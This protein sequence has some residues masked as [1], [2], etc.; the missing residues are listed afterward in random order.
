MQLENETR[1]WIL[2]CVDK[3]DLDKWF[4]AISLQIQQV[5]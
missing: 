3:I 5:A 4:T 1:K 2:A